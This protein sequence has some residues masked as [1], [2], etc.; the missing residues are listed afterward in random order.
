MN[1]MEPT[2]RCYRC[3]QARPLSAFITRVDDRHYAMCRP[4]VSEILA[5]RPAGQR[6]RLTHTATQRTCYLCRRVLPV[7][8]FT[9]RWQRL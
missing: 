8:Q 4:C 1:E 3:G 9:Q 6:E 7:D 2:R 5:A